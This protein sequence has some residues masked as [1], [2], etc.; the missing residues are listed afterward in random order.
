MSHAR[1]GHAAR[2]SESIHCRI[3]NFCACEKRPSSPDS[4]SQGNLAIVEKYSYVVAAR[5]CHL[6]C[7]SKA[8]SG[9]IV[10]F[11]AGKIGPVIAASKQNFPIRQQR[12]SVSY[13]PRA[14]TLN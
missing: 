5:R 7:G 4:A 12:C 8:S 6:T 11:C 2:S 10:N 9:G 3:V 14:H 1:F 13:A